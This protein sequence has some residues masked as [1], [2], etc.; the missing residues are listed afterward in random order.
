MSWREGN[1]ERRGREGGGGEAKR[2]NS[3]DFGLG[4]NNKKNKKIN[5][6]R[7]ADLLVHNH[8]EGAVY[9]IVCSVPLRVD[10]RDRIPNCDASGCLLK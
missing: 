6:V 1:H 5:E 10:D 3:E 4:K 8:N 2:T 7:G 9:I